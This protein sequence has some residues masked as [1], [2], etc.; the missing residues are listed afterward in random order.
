MCI[1]STIFLIEFLFFPFFFFL[2]W[3]VKYSAPH[4]NNTCPNE[5]NPVPDHRKTMRCDDKIDRQLDE[6]H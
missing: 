3:A 2:F 4:T 6:T 5:S 1:A